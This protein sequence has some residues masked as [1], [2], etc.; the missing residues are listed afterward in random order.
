MVR[1]KTLSIESDTVTPQYILISITNHDNNSISDNKVSL[2]LRFD[3]EEAN[4]RYG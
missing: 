4:K 3:S 2:F 1:V